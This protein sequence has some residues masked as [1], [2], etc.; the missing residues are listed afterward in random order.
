MEPVDLLFTV[1]GL[2]VAGGIEREENSGFVEAVFDHIVEQCVASEVLITPDLD[3]ADTTKTLR[4]LDLQG[5]YETPEPSPLGH[6]HGS[7]R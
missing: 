4:Q 7:S 3:Q 2:I 5:F 1:V 6:R